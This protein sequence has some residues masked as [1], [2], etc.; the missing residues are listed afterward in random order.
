MLDSSTAYKKAI[1]ENGRVMSIHDI[2]KF[3]DGS[4]LPINTG[5]LKKY[6]INE[7]TS[8]N[9]SFSIGATVIKAYTA[10]LDNTDGKF[11]TVDFEGLDIVAKVGLLLPDGSIEPIP[12]GK[13]RCVSAKVGE[14]AVDVK[15]YDSMIFFDRPYADSTLIYPATI[16]QIVQDACNCCQMTFDAKTIQ[17]GSL[18]IQ[19]RPDDSGLTFR[20]VIGYCAQMMCCYAI[21]NK[22]DQLSFGWYDFST[23][24]SLQKSYDGG[25]FGTDDTPYSDGDVLDGG[26]FTDYYSGDTADGG[27]FEGQKLYHHLY[28][29]G[30]QSINTDDICI[31]GIA[32]KPMQ[33]ED[34]DEVCLYGDDDY[35][36]LIEDNPLIQSL[37]MAEAVAAYAGEKM[38]GKKF[39]PLSITCQSDPCMEAGDCACVTDRKK[40]TFFTVIT[41]TTFSLGSLQHVECTAETPTEKNYTKYSATTKILNKA[42]NEARKQLITYDLAVRQLTDLMSQSF[43]IFKTEEKQEDGS[44]IYY[45]HNKPELSSSS[46]IWK[47]TA[48]ALAVSTDGGQT[49][50]A[51]IDSEGNVLVNVLS[52][53]GIKFDW[54]KGGTLTLGGEDNVDGVLKVYNADGDVVCS[55]TK[56]GLKVVGALIESSKYTATGQ[57]VKYASDYTE[58]DIERMKKIIL[59]IIDPTMDDFERYDFNGDGRINLSDMVKVKRF[60]D[61]YDESYSL[62]SSITINP[63]N[64]FSLI[65]TSGVSIGIS[66]IYSQNI[67]AKHLQVGGVSDGACIHP[68]DKKRGFYTDAVEDNTYD[69]PGYIMR[70]SSG[71]VT[72]M[73]VS[74]LHFS[75]SNGEYYKFPDG[76]LI[77]VKKRSLMFSCH[78]TWGSLHDS[79]VIDLGNWPC[80]FNEIPTI[81]ATFCTDNS[82]AWPEGF[83]NVSATSAGSTYLCRAT[84]TDTLIT[85]TLHVTG[86][87]R[88]K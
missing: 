81:S 28:S 2:Y 70:T 21:I 48:D 85:G 37:E 86:I 33:D 88:W 45:M 47:M 22:L 58:D 68:Y 16:L 9:A 69:L 3:A 26:N 60:L 39:R 52:A 84:D 61:G 49:W 55:I 35:A 40:R 76:T 56:D 73:S 18:V 19:E 12:K 46:T 29:I 25:T 64:A 23:L 32:V 15:A 42:K 24:E 11:D 30:S 36:L 79:D 54:A 71:I 83:T 59:G 43:G 82:F 67:T 75:N 80:A 7:A 57:A 78:N 14:N 74:E 13:Y 27:T 62:D 65:K 20:D 44:I 53:I 51:G 17:N 77:C 10:T 87:G 6:S 66:G 63:A 38:V 5:N 8:D 4:E 1:R 34:T 31:S 72:E 41:N 50:N